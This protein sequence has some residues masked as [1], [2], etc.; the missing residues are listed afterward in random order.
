MST[1]R[2]MLRRFAVLTFLATA[3]GLAGCG[4]TPDKSCD[5]PQRYQAAREA[6]PVVVPDDLDQLD[7]FKQLP[8]PQ[9]SPRPPRAE[10]SPCLDLPPSILGDGQQ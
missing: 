5:E 4:G 1:M 9:A 8:L 2:F 3:A 6:D 7:E 10:G